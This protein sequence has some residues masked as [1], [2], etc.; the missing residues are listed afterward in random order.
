MKINSM[1]IL[2]L[3][4]K[5]KFIGFENYISKV[6]R[7]YILPRQI[8]ED[9]YYKTNVGEVKFSTMFLLRKIFCSH[10]IEPIYSSK[11]IN[12]A[13]RKYFNYYYCHK[14]GFYQCHLEDEAK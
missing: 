11:G 3:S 12:G 4:D 5:V 7:G 6:G 13:E 9:M 10:K 2:D 1:C 14:C 8:A